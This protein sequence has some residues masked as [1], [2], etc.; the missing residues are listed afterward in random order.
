MNGVDTFTDE[1]TVK[2]PDMSCVGSDGTSV[3]SLRWTLDAVTRR[4]V[5]FRSTEGTFTQNPEAS[6][7][8]TP[9]LRVGV[10]SVSVLNVMAIGFANRVPEGSR[11]YAPPTPFGAV[12]VI[13]WI[14]NCVVAAIAPAGIATASRPSAEVITPPPAPMDAVTAVP[15]G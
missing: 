3:Q 1:F 4:A 8:T 6:W 2:V 15:V 14:E 10:W 5:V 7:Y 11:R 12:L 9:R 13:G